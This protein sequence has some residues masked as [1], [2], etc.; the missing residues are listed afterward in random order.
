MII[1]ESIL[2]TFEA[3]IIFWGSGGSSE[4]QLEPITISKFN[5]VKLVQFID[6]VLIGATEHCKPYLEIALRMGTL[7]SFAISWSNFGTFSGFRS[8][9]RAAKLSRFRTLGCF[10]DAFWD[11][12]ST[13]TGRSE[14]WWIKFLTLWL[15]DISNIRMIEKND[16]KL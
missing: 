10:V 13:K 15:L 1:F 11:D 12:F 2:T 5:Q 7:L 3:I 9:K 14:I 6:T 4:N 16:I 8:R